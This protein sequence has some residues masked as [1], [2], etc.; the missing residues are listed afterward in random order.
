MWRKI[1]IALL[2]IFLLSFPPALKAQSEEA[3]SKERSRF[4]LQFALGNQTTG[5]PFENWFSGF[6][7]S[8][9]EIGLLFRLNKHPKHV[10]Y[11]NLANS[12]QFNSTTGSAYT[13]TLGLGYR[14]VHQT[15]FCGGVNLALGSRIG[16]YPRET[17]RY[18]P[19]TQQYSQGQKTFSSGYSGFGWMLGYDLW[20][21]HGL[22]YLVFLRNS[23]GFQAPYFPIESIPALPQNVLE[24]GLVLHLFKRSQ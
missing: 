1:S 23:F 2:G 14:Y 15:G 17:L 24:A 12:W 7:P 22:R 9:S 10:L 19:G 20:P 3:A 4:A 11:A 16:F 21:R 13:G 5:F 8:I 18:D 6:N